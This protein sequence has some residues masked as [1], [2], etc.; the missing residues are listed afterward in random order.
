MKEINYNPEGTDVNSEWIELQNTSS[1]VLKISQYRFLESYLTTIN[2]HKRIKIFI[3]K[4]GHIRHV[5]TYGEK[6]HKNFFVNMY[7]FLLCGTC[8]QIVWRSHIARVF[9][10]KTQINYVTEGRVARNYFRFFK[11]CIKKDFHLCRSYIQDTRSGVY[12]WVWSI[13]YIRDTYVL[14]YGE[15]KVSKNF[16]I[17]LLLLILRGTSREIKLVPY[18]D[19]TYSFARHLSNVRV[20]KKF[21]KSLS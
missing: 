20:A 16:F 12:F 15:K 7:Y 9:F 21:F 17:N 3:L 10:E 4:K 11:A 8:R 14:Q 1:F 18:R 6:I 19:Y 2:S 5:L 13:Q